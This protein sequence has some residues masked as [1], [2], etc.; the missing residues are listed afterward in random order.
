V[1]VFLSTRF[2]ILSNMISI[3]KTALLPYIRPLNAFEMAGGHCLDPYT[4]VV[5]PDGTVDLVPL[6]ILTVNV[7]SL[8]AKKP[9]ALVFTE[10]GYDWYVYDPVTKEISMV[11]QGHNLMRARGLLEDLVPLN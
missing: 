8:M 10:V 11:G 5:M 3:V 2:S 4:G 7:D 6:D 1:K 9:L